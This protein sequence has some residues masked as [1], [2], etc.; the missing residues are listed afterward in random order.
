MREAPF[1]VKFTERRQIAI[2]KMTHGIPSEGGRVGKQTLVDMI[3]TAFN[4]G[5]LAGI[6]ASLEVVETYDH[7]I[8]NAIRRELLK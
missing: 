6:S 7:Q 5:V 1:L 3:A 8:A 2:G 4:G